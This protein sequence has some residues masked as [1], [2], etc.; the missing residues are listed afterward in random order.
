MLTHQNYHQWRRDME[1]LLQAEEAPDAVLSDYELPSRRRS[2]EFAQCHLS[3]VHQG[4][5]R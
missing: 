3:H 2:S 5:Y 1:F 4:L